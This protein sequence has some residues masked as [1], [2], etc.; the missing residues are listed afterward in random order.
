MSRLTIVWAALVAATCVSW[1]VGAAALAIAFVKVRYIGLEF[2]ELRGADAVLRGLFEAYVLVVG[3]TLLALHALAER[4]SCSRATDP[5]G[6][7]P[8]GSTISVVTPASR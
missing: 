2:M 6:S 5:S 7:G 1:S 3:A 4:S 8:T